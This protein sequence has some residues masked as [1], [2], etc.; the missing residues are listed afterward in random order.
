[1]EANKIYTRTKSVD[2]IGCECAADHTLP[3]YKGDVK[4]VLFTDCRIV[5]EGTFPDGNRLD[6]IG[7]VELCIV[8]LDSE[9]ELEHCEF[10]ADYDT[11]VPCDG[12]QYAAASSALDVQS[13]SIRLTGPR[14]LS[15]RAV[16]GGSVEITENAEITVGGDALE[17]EDAELLTQDLMIADMACVRSEKK[18]YTDVLERMEGVIADE[19]EVL[20]RGAEVRIKDASCS[21]GRGEHSG[22][23]CITAL[24]KCANEQPHIVEKV[25]PFS[26]IFELECGEELDAR[27]ISSRL[28]VKDLQTVVNMDEGGSSVEFKAEVEGEMKVYGNSRVTVVKDCFLTRSECE[29]ERGVMNYT[30]FVDQA[31]GSGEV[32]E[33]VP[34]E[35]VG[36]GDVRNIVIADAKAHLDHV[37]MKD[38][39]AELCGEIRFSG[40]ACEINC[41]NEPEYQSIRVEIPF[42]ENVNISGQISETAA[43][44]ASVRAWGGEM[45]LDGDA[46]CLYCKLDM[47]VFVTDERSEEVVISAS[48]NGEE[49]AVTDGVVTVYYP[50]EGETLFDIAKRYHKSMVCVAADNSLTESVFAAKDRS[51]RSLGIDRIIIK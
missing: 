12:E 6:L 16:L 46:L 24:V 43:L 48:G 36:I 37:E 13:Y 49:L 21:E 45:T 29:C 25:I 33:L 2:G 20:Y 9:G 47:S 30:T 26:D 50:E 3:D 39:Y 8:Y 51:A 41:D 14:K 17:R 23:L 11:Y 38:G 22:E 28:I 15:A 44:D 27:S 32:S 34:K 35:S 19:V 4:R 40:I 31:L 7:K 10:Y 18:E 5:E 42:K 1:M